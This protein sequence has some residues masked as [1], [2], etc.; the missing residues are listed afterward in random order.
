M[1]QPTQITLLESNGELLAFHKPAGLPSAPHSSRPTE[2]S[3]LTRVLAQYPELAGVQGLQSWE[4]ALLHRLDTGTSGV[5]L[6][7][8]TQ[9]AFAD[10]RARWKTFSKTYRAWVIPKTP[11]ARAMLSALPHTVE[12]PLAHSAKSAK[13]MLAVTPDLPANRVR[14][15]ALPA[16]TEIVRVHAQRGEYLDLEIRIQTGVM[17]QIRAHLAACGLPIVGD[18]IYG[19]PHELGMQLHAWRI[20]IPGASGDG[21]GGSDDSIEAPLAR[22][23]WLGDPPR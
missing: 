10:L 22:G 17:H 8:R 18:T 1:P 16:R 3:A 21:S 20:M 4:P 2:D 7:A 12:W 6:F 23:L 13:R 9:E 14:G 11:E 19:T 5:L 15:R